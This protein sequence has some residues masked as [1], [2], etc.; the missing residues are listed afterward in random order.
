MKWSSQ[1]QAKVK[2]NLKNIDSTYLKDAYKW[3]HFVGMNSWKKRWTM[4]R[5][6][7]VA[8][9]EEFLEQVNE[10]TDAPSSIQAEL[11]KTKTGM[12]CKAKTTGETVERTLG[13]L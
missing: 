4:S 5:P 13:E 3:H 7:N 6:V 12:K 2:E 11:T 10:H 9:A 1:I 8:P